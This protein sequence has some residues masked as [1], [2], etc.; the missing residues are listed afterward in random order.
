MNHKRELRDGVHRNRYLL[1][2]WK[3]HGPDAFIFS[4]HTDCSTVDAAS[5]ATI[6]NQAE[7]TLLSSFTKTYNLMEAALSGTVA[8]PETKEILSR[9]SLEMWQDPEFKKSRSLATKALYANP[10]WKA[11]RDVAVLEGKRTPEAKAK[12]SLRFQKMWSD[13]EHKASQSA[14]RTANWQDPEYKAKQKASRLAA[15][16]DPE[17]RKRRSEGLKASHARRKAA[18]LASST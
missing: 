11:A 10:V 18:R 15:S 7:L 9:K 17:V 6:L 16:A 14:K 3:K 5:L 2:S 1:N 8:S 4:I 12:A 13:P